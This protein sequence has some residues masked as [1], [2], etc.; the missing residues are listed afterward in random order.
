MST[1]NLVLGACAT[2]LAVGSAFASY[3]ASVNIRIKN[4]TSGGAPILITVDNA[5]TCSG[6]TKCLLKVRTANNVNTVFLAAT[7][8]TIG[9]TTIPGAGLLQTIGR[10]LGN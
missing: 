5:P 1:R 2:C 6:A 4:P 7:I 8:V 10:T 3:L 9:G